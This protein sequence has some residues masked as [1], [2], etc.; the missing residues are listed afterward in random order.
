M[1]GF[2]WRISLVLFSHWSSLLP[3]SLPPVSISN[4]L[5]FSRLKVSIAMIIYLTMLTL[6]LPSQANIVMLKLCL[7]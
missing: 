2:I 3:F 6:I 7:Q 5:L 4:Q 1:N